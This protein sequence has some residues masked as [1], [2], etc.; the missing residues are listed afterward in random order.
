MTITM[1]SDL[2]IYNLYGDCLNP[3]DG[4]SLSRYQADSHH[5]FRHYQETNKSQVEG[6]KQVKEKMS[7]CYIK[8]RKH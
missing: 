7:N 2:N 8:F 5:L 3:A 1:N 4:I 6:I